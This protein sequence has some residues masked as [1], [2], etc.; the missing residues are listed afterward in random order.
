[1]SPEREDNRGGGADGGGGSGEGGGRER[2]RESFSAWLGVLSAFREAIEESIS[3]LRDR[4]DLSPERARE[5]VRST[6][7]RAQ[8]AMEDARERLDMVP[9][10]EFDS[11][12]TEVDDLRRRLARLEGDAARRIPIEGE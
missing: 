12:R 8:S 5:A 2:G 11:L 1:M 9:R 6:M 3:E 10:R 4:G 7:R